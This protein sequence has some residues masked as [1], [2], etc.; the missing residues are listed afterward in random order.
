MVGSQVGKTM[1]K[2]LMHS[3][4]L[5]MTSKLA[6][7]SDAVILCVCKLKANEWRSK[8]NTEPG[9]EAKFTH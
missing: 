6:D 1:L 3:I 9:L 4:N 5:T 7:F 2:V 8:Y